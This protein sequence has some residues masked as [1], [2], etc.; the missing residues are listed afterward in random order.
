MK[1]VLLVLFYL[2]VWYANSQDFAAILAAGNKDASTYLG[3]YLEPVYK[4]LIYDLSNGW[5]HTGKT[6]KK[7]GFDVTISATAAFIPNEDKVF[8][9]NNSDYE[10]LE[11]EGGLSSDNL[12]TVMGAKSDKRIN[13]TIPLAGGVGFKTSSFETLDGQEDEMPVSA[14]ITPMVQIGF[15]LPSKTDIKVRYVPTIETEDIS[16]N[17]F[18]IGL[19]HNILQHFKV[20][21][22]IP[23]IAV[24]I[25]GAFTTSTIIQTP[26]DVTTTKLVA[27]NQETIFKVNSYTAQLLG[28]VNLKI[29]NFYAGLGYVGGATTTQIKG[30][31]AITYSHLNQFGVPIGE[32]EIN[33]VDPINMN[34][35]ISSMKATL[36]MRLNIMWFKIFADYT[37]QEYNTVNAGIAFS[38]R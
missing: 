20:A 9:F 17:L 28:N 18:G 38:F 8:T 5:Y 31:Y 16:F 19:Q 27:R 36:G 3:N 25:L 12:P 29:V 13:I 4:G 2:T 30:D 11:L 10:V 34:Y 23:L 35:T 26:E 37:V 7:Y 24:S 6:H 14:I 22:K 1:K 33:I 21:D 15:G 32:T